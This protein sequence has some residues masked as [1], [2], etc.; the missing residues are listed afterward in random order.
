M[1]QGTCCQ[2]MAIQNTAGNRG[3]FFLFVCLFQWISLRL[4]LWCTATSNVRDTSAVLLNGTFH[5]GRFFW[6][7]RRQCSS[8]FHEAT[9]YYA[10]FPR[11]STQKRASWQFQLAIYLRGLHRPLGRS[12]S[13]NLST[14][15]TAFLFQ[16]WFFSWCSASVLRDRG[17]SLDVFFHYSL[18]IFCW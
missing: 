14:G 9:L 7:F 2:Q 12:H 4:L 3:G 8:K 18:E 1:A 10:Q 11:L 15:G 17:S 5:H 13:H 16:I 6:H